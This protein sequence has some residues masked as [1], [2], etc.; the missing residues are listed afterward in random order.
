MTDTTLKIINRRPLLK[1]SSPG[2]QGKTGAGITVLGEL[3]STSNLPATPNDNLSPGDAYIIAGDLWVY[4]SSGTFVNSGFVE[5]APGPQGEIGPQGI[6]GPQGEPGPIGATGPQ[7]IQG[8][9]G[10]KGDRGT[11]IAVKGTLGSE[12]E[13]PALPQ[14]PEDAYIIS[15]DMYVW[16][17]SSWTNVGAF[18]GPQGEQGPIG[19]TGPKGDTGATGP[20][21]IQGPIGLTGPT[22]P[23][24][25][26]GATG[27]TGLTGPKGDTGDTGP[28]GPIGLTGPQGDTGPKGDSAYAVAVANG[29]VGTEAEWLASL[30]GP[31]GPQ[32]IQGETGP[33]GIPGPKGD[34]GDTGPQ[35]IQGNPG[36]Q[37][38]QGPTG[39]SITNAQFSAVGTV[40]TFTGATRYYVQ[41]A[42]NIVMSKAS[43][44]TAGSTATTIVVKKNGTTVHTDTIAASTNVIT[45]TTVVAVAANDY[46]TIDCTAAGTG[47]KDLVVMV[48]IEE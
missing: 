24:G 33:Q 44:G 32:G 18:Q 42:G 13:L 5:G 16:D 11:G 37:G 47:A 38:I 45:N 6:Q 19:P 15:G 21:G 23:Q 35:G 2:P 7:G 36:P 8:I 30:E 40:A 9:P 12:A 25:A 34:T 3:A 46:L 48:R 27:P 1:I 22:G 28:Q 41:N 14:E 31:Q 4:A 26:T 43:L 20:Q 39:K 17:G 10:P 29:F